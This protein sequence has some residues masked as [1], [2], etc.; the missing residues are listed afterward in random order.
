MNTSINVPKLG[1]NNPNGSKYSWYIAFVGH[2]SE[3]CK[4]DLCQRK[5]RNDRRSEEHI[6]N[7]NGKKLSGQDGEELGL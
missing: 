6:T 2:L 1:Y 7:R 3:S 5:T 4:T